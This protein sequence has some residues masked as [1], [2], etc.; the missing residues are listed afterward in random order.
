MCNGQHPNGPTDL[1]ICNVVREDLEIH[2]PITTRSQTGN[3]NMLYNPTNVPID[4][5]AEFLPKLRLFVLIID[6]GVLEFS[7][8]F[9]QENDL[10]EA[11]RRSTRAKTSS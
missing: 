1:G 7:R 3:L 9:R 10:H 5:I 2:S 8:R 6:N 4:L 11:R